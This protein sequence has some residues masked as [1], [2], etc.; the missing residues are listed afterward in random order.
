VA[1]A[2]GSVGTLFPAELWSDVRI[3]RGS[4]RSGGTFSVLT[5]EVITERR[6]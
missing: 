5:Q 3:Q 4:W 2:E 1:F 6:L